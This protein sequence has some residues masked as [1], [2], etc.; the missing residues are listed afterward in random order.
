MNNFMLKNQTAKRLYDEV[1]SLPIID[2]HCHLSAEEIYIDEK[3]NSLTDLWLRGDH[4]KW[5]QMRTFGIDEEKITGNAPDYEKFAAFMQTLEFAAGNPLYHWSKLELAAYFGIF[6]ELTAKNTEI[7]WEKAK[8]HIENVGFSPIY[9]INSSNVYAV[10]TTEEI[11]CDLKFHKLLADDK[12]LKTRILPGFRGDRAFNISSPEFKQNIEKLAA[13]T[14]I[15]IS[16][17]SGLKKA[18]CIQLD[19][20]LDAGCIS[21]DF[22]FEGFSY[23]EMSQADLEITFKKGLAG[24]VTNED[25]YISYVL[26]FLLEECYKRDFAVQLHIG[27][28]RNN[29]TKMFEKLGADT[30]FDTMSARPYL[31]GLRG[32]LDAVEKSVGLGRTILFHL[33]PAYMS[34]MAALCGCYQGGE[35]GKIQLGAA[36]WFNDTKAGMT[37]HLEIFGELMT[38]GTFVGMLTDSRSFI[39]YPRHDYFRRILCSFLGELSEGGEYTRDFD[40]LSTLAKNISFYNAKNYFRL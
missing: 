31:D 15:A 7:I 20:F 24:E 18:L 36:W 21:C 13:V 30:G 19:R 40:T 39:S 32:L 2:Y 11:F 12:R 26:K 25:A 28:M 16:D 8:K 9:A 14:G 3:V 29:N 5:R 38:L 34:E 10:A 33:N 6:D 4:Y 37:R 23:T 17:L 1:K 35:R 27:A 22:A